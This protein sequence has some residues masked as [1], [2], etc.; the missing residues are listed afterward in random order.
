MEKRPYTRPRWRKPGPPL[1]PAQESARLLVRIRPCHAGMFR[2]LLEGYEHL[3]YF[4]V[5]NKYEGLLKIVYSPHRERAVRQALAEIG[6]S[7]PLEVLP[8]P[9]V[10]SINGF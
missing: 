5:L 2:F 8:W 6:D 4:T 1:P 7:L 3:A 10:L 9:R